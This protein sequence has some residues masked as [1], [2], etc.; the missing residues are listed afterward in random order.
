VGSIW[1]DQSK[2]KAENLER[3][4]LLPLRLI[5]PGRFW[6]SL[7]YA[8]RLYLFGL[9]G[10]VLTLD[11][12]R[13]IESWQIDDS[14]RIAFDCAFRQSN[15]L[16]GHNIARLFNDPEIRDVMRG[17]F[18]RLAQT[19]Y[20]LP[21]ARLRECSV[22]E[23]S[24][25]FPFPHTDAAIYGNNFYVTTRDGVYQASCEK[26]NGN[27]ISS[28][29]ERKWDGGA[30][31]VAISYNS[32]AL[33]AGDEGLFELPIEGEIQRPGARG[34]RQIVSQNCTDCRWTF[35]SIYC[36]SHIGMG[37]LAS[38]R[39]EASAGR[40]SPYERKFDH[41]ISSREIFHDSFG[42]SW[43][44][45]DKLC[46][47]DDHG[48]HIV[49]YQPWAEEAAIENLGTVDIETLSDEKT[50][51]L[52]PWKSRVVS[53]ATALFGT[54]VEC[55]NAIVV[56]PSEGPVLTLKGEPT[57]WRIFT[58]SIQYENQL[59]VLYPERIEILSFNQDY[60]VNQERKLHGLNAKYVGVYSEGPARSGK[61]RSILRRRFLE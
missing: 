9:D 26:T 21:E 47:L 33:A 45:Q 30:Y 8:G 24:S 25:P 19:V 14:V 2:P 18:E 44:N 59:H 48:I 55:Q 32:L 13:L 17:K 10:K 61:Q 58:R 11:W 39:K 56:I 54:V 1:S 53:G 3:A 34:P 6:D 49:R 50:I 52:D 16:Y 43:G 41:P 15:L 35:Y 23:Q 20:E 27:P 57:N 40:E 60:F 22:G 42:Y 12:D 46:Q 31:S 7:I 4:A 38:F 5:I 51:D 29:V 36:S 37:Y 28:H